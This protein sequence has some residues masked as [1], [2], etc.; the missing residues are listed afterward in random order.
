VAEH[1]WI[2]GLA[3]STPLAEAARHVLALRLEAVRE[4]LGAAL[5]PS[6]KD[7][8]NV[9]QLRVSTRRARAAFDIFCPC[10]PEK[11]LHEGRRR[12]RRLRR[13]AGDARDW[14]VFL[15]TIH[16]ESLKKALRRGPGFDF[17][18]GYALS[19]RAAAQER[20]VKIGRDHP[21]A[22]DRLLSDTISSV[23]R[24]HARQAPRLLGDLATPLLAE[25]L[26]KLDEAAR[27]D[28]YAY[29]N[30]HQLRIAGKRLRYAIEVIAACFAAPL[31]EQIYPAV[32]AMQDILGRANDS[33]VAQERLHEL[34]AQLQQRAP[35]EWKRLRPGALGLLHFHEQRVAQ[36]RKRFLAWWRRW[37]KPLAEKTANKMTKSP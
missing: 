7:V 14:D 35:C 33:Q 8:E 36:E 16:Q 23:Q 37:Q 29:K 12:L 19:Q 22:I 26:N 4:F 24:P 25:L 15:E 18:S 28:L 2:E 9:H 31:R 30:L 3:K 34:C 20:L 27:A 6:D 13:A 11:I 10:L 1:K 21:S 17:V 5:Q 32:E